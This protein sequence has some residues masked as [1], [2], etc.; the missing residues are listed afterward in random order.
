MKIFISGGTGFIGTRLSMHLAEAGHI[1]TVGTRNPK[2]KR[3]GRIDYINYDDI[4]ELPNQDVVIHLATEYGRKIE[5]SAPI[6]DAN[7]LLP[8]RL[9]DFSIKKHVRAFINTDSYYSKINGNHHLKRYIISKKMFR[10][11]CGFLSAASIKIIHL[12]LE[13]VYGPGDSKDKFC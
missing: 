7:I 6:I 2:S 13:H 8:V 12:Y 5:E 1:V 10:E 11:W 4:N 3:S 9:L